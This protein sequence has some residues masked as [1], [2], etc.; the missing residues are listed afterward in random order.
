[1]SSVFLVSCQPGEEGVAKVHATRRAVDRLASSTSTGLVT[2]GNVSNEM[3]EEEQSSDDDEMTRVDLSTRSATP[4][5]EYSAVSRET[6]SMRRA[7]NQTDESGMTLRTREK[8]KRVLEDSESEEGEEEEEEKETEAM[9]TLQRKRRTKTP[10]K[11]CRRVSSSS[12]NDSVSLPLLHSTVTTS[13]G[14]TVKPTSK[15]V[16]R[17][18]ES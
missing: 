10:R 14:R 18:Y 15:S 9:V 4:A 16:V 3:V 17:M 6:R 11:R 2:P 1:M 12:D 13:R 7:R 8:R 5:S